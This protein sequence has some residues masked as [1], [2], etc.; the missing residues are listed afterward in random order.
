MSYAIFR[1]GGKQFRAEQGR[2]LRVPLLAAEPG[3][4]VTFDQ[5]LLAHS[6]DKV[7]TGTPLIDGAAV[8]AQ[9]VGHGRDKKIVVFKHKRRKNY[10]RKTGHRQ[11][12][13]EVRIKALKVS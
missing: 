9:V 4:S 2:T 3:A 11:D 7:V 10:R 13:T 6:G 1:T 12:F 5:V 8:E